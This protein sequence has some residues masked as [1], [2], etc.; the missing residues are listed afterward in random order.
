MEHL[1]KRR[2]ALGGGGCSEDR[3]NTITQEYRRS[4]ELH[5]KIIAII[6]EEWP[7]P[8]NKLEATTISERLQSE[9]VEV[10]EQAVLGVLL[11]LSEHGDIVLAL[12][13]PHQPS[14]DVS[15]LSVSQTL[16]E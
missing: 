1:R 7:N 15:I 13:T 11:Q 16:C 2:S 3:R 10:S 5:E 4:F 14:T 8:D 9:G 6:C 12:P